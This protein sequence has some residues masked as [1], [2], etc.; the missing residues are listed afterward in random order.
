MSTSDTQS[1]PAPVTT[2]AF[3]FLADTSGRPLA[4]PAASATIT[5]GTKPGWY[6]ATF[7]PPVIVK[8]PF[9]LSWSPGNTQPLFRDPIVNRGTPSA[10]YKRTVAGPWTGPAKN[11]AWAWRVLCAGAAGVLSP[12]FDER[13]GSSESK[14]QRG[15]GSR[16]SSKQSRRQKRPRLPVPG[17]K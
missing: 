9:F 7:T 15:G 6:R 17:Q 11:R 4:T 8:Q 2:N 3:I 5:V 1:L 14:R 12:A 16:P 13:P 10:H